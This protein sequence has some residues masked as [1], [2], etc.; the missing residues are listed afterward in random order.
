MYKCGEFLHINNFVTSG[1]SAERD[2]VIA[3]LESLIAMV[4][5]IKSVS[6]AAEAERSAAR[7]TVRDFLLGL[8]PMREEFVEGNQDAFSLPKS[9]FG[10]FCSAFIVGLS[11][12][13]HL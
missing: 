10:R 2:R 1:S 6:D 12:K 3:D 11:R 8:G 13:L 7:E 4:D 5:A 9:C